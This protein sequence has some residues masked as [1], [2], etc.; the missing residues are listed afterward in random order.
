VYGE[1]HA[2]VALLILQPDIRKR[3]FTS[4]DM[5]PYHRFQLTLQFYIRLN[6]DVIVLVVTNQ[7]KGDHPMGPALSFKYGCH[8]CGHN[9][10]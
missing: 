4:I 8:A 3:H 5:F 7:N 6:E 10:R 9:L 1:G 2:T